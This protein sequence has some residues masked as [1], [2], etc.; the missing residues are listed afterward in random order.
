LD[1][2]VSDLSL[3]YVSNTGRDVTE[4]ATNTFAVSNPP[5]ASD[6]PATITVKVPLGMQVPPVAIRGTGTD[7]IEVEMRGLDDAVSGKH[8]L[9][10]SSFV[11]NDTLSLCHLQLHGRTVE[12][13]KTHIAAYT[14]VAELTDVVFGSIMN[15]AQLTL[16]EE[17]FSSQTWDMRTFQ[18]DTHALEFDA[19][20]AMNITNR[21]TYHTLSFGFLDVSSMTGGGGGDV[22][23]TSPRTTVM[24]TF[25]SREYYCLGGR[26]VI[27]FNT[28]CSMNVSAPVNGTAYS[29]QTHSCPQIHSAWAIPRVDTSPDDQVAYLHLAV[30]DGGIY[31]TVED[32]TA[33]G[34]QCHRGQG[35]IA[36][37]SAME[38]FGGFP[39]GF[40]T[41]G[42]SL[43][44]K[45]NEWINDGTGYDAAVVVRLYGPKELQG[46]GHWVFCTLK[47]Y[48]V[49]TIRWIT[50]VSGSI[51]TPKLA[52]L[53]A[54][55]VPNVC[56]YCPAAQAYSNIQVQG[57]I[58]ELFLQQLG[59]VTSGNDNVMLLVKQ[60]QDTMHYF[61][62]E[63]PS[64]RAEIYSYGL[65]SNLNWIRTSETLSSYPLI[66]LVLST[67]I[68]IGA[69]GV[70]CYVVWAMAIWAFN[71]HH[72]YLMRQLRYAHMKQQLEAEDEG[73]A[74]KKKV[75]S[76]NTH[77]TVVSQGILSTKV[78]K[79]L[80]ENKPSGVSRPFSHSAFFHI[81]M[82]VEFMRRS[83]VDPLELFIYS[84]PEKDG[85]QDGLVTG[86]DDAQ[87]L[88][89]EQEADDGGEVSH[90]QAAGERELNF[91]PL[92][93]FKM[94][95]N[96]FCMQH[97][98]LP[99]GK[100]QD[101]KLI[102]KLAGLAIKRNVSQVDSFVCLGWRH[103]PAATMDAIVADAANKTNRLTDSVTMFLQ[104]NC[105]AT[106]Q[107]TD[108]IPVQELSAR[109]N[110][111]CHRL[112][113]PQ[114][115]RMYIDNG[116]QQV[117]AFG[118]QLVPRQESLLVEG[119]YVDTIQV[120]REVPLAK[121]LTAELK[122]AVKVDFS[123]GNI[124]KQLKN[125]VFKRA[126]SAMDRLMA[127]CFMEIE[128]GLYRPRLQL[129]QW[130]HLGLKCIFSPYSKLWDLVLPA[131]QVGVVFLLPLPLFM[132]G[133]YVQ[134]SD[135][136]MYASDPEIDIFVWSD[137]TYLWTYSDRTVMRAKFAHMRPL[138][139]CIFF[140]IPIYITIGLA[141][142]ACHI[143]G[144]RAWDPEAFVQHSYL[145]RL[146]TGTFNSLCLLTLFAYASFVG[147][148]AAWLLLGAILNPDAFLPYGVAVLT[149]GTVALQR[150]RSLKQMYESTLEKITGCTADILNEFLL[151]P[152]KDVLAPLEA[153]EELQQAAVSKLSHLPGLD[154]IDADLLLKSIANN[155]FSG[156]SAQLAAQPLVSSLGL[157][158]DAIQCI[159]KGELDAVE[160]H[161]SK[162]LHVRSKRGRAV[163]RAILSTCPPWG[164]ASPPPGLLQAVEMLSQEANIPVP[165]AKALASF[166]FASVRYK[167]GKTQW[168]AAT[169]HLLEQ[170][171]AMEVAQKSQS[172]HP[173]YRLLREVIGSEIL[174]CVINLAL[175][176]MRGLVL[177]LERY[178]HTPA[179]EALLKIARWYS[180]GSG[181][182]T[183]SGLEPQALQSLRDDLATFS[184]KWLNIK[185][186][187]FT[188]LADLASGT[189]VQLEFLS[190]ALNLKVS[191]LRSYLQ[192]TA[193]R[194]DATLLHSAVGQLVKLMGPEPQTSSFMFGLSSTVYGNNLAD[195]QEAALRRMYKPGAAAIWCAC[196]H[197]SS[198]AAPL[199][200][201]DMR[202]VVLALKSSKQRVLMEIAAVAISGTSATAN[203]L[204]NISLLLG[205]PRHAIRHFGLCVL[206]FADNERLYIEDEEKVK[207]WKSVASRLARRARI[208]RMWRTMMM[209]PGG[210]QERANRLAKMSKEETARSLQSVG[211]KVGSIGS[212]LTVTAGRNQK[213]A[214]GSGDKSISGRALQMALSPEAPPTH[215][216][217][218]KAILKSFPNHQHQQAVLALAH[219]A[220][221][222]PTEVALSTLARLLQLDKEV[223]SLLVDLT[224][225]DF[226][227]VL[228][229]RTQEL[230]EKREKVQAAAEEAKVKALKS[231][232]ASLKAGST[233]KKIRSTQGSARSVYKLLNAHG[234]PARLG[235]GSAE[236]ISVSELDSDMVQNRFSQLPAVQ[237]LPLCRGERLKLLSLVTGLP[238]LEV[239]TTAQ[240][241]RRWCEWGEARNDFINHMAGAMN[242]NPRSMFTLMRACGIQRPSAR[243][244]RAKGSQ[245]LGAGAVGRARRMLS[246]LHD[247]LADAH[248]T[249]QDSFL[250]V[251]GEV[252]HKASSEKQ[253]TPP[254]LLEEDEEGAVP[255][256]SS[257]S[258]DIAQAVTEVYAGE[259]KVFPELTQSVSPD[260]K[261][262][263]PGVLAAVTQHAEHSTHS[264]P[265]QHAEHAAGSADGSRGAVPMN[266][267]AVTH[268]RAAAAMLMNLHSTNLEAVLC[269]KLLHMVGSKQ[270]HEKSFASHLNK[271][272]QDVGKL[273]EQLQ[274]N[275]RPPN[276]ISEQ[277]QGRILQGTGDKLASDS[278]TDTDRPA[279]DELED[280]LL[281]H[282]LTKS[283]WTSTANV[284]RGHHSFAFLG[285]Y[286]QACRMQHLAQQAA[287]RSPCAGRTLPIE[288]SGFTLPPRMWETVKQVTYTLDMVKVLH[289]E[290][291]DGHKTAAQTA[292][293]LLQAAFVSKLGD[294]KCLQEVF[295]PLV[296]LVNLRG[297]A[298]VRTNFLLALAVG[299]PPGETQIMQKAFSSG[300]IRAVT[301]VPA[302]LLSSTVAL[303]HHDTASITFAAQFF[304][305]ELR[306]SNETLTGMLAAVKHMPDTLGVLPSL[307]GIPPNLASALVAVT[308]H[309]SQPRNPRQ[310]G[311][312]GV[313]IGMEQ[314]L[315]IDNLVDILHGKPQCVTQL[316]WEKEVEEVH[317]ELLLADAIAAAAAGRQMQDH[318]LVAII[319]RLVRHVHAPLPANQMREQSSFEPGIWGSP[320]SHHGHNTPSPASPDA[321]PDTDEHN[322]GQAAMR[323]QHGISMM[324]RL[325]RGDTNA[326]A[327]LVLEL[328]EL[329]SRHWDAL[330]ALVEDCSVSPDDPDAQPRLASAAPQPDMLASTVSRFRTGSGSQGPLHSAEFPRYNSVTNNR[331]RPASI[332]IQDH[333]PYHE[334]T[335]PMQGSRRVYNKQPPREEL[336][337]LQEMSSRVLLVVEYVLRNPHEFHE[338][339][340]IW[341]DPS[342][343]VPM[344]NNCQAFFMDV[345]AC[346]GRVEC[347]QL[348]QEAAWVLPGVTMFSRMMMLSAAIVLPD[349]YML[350]VPAMEGQL[351][352]SDEP[353]PAQCSP[354]NDAVNT[355]AEAEVPL[356]PSPESA[357]K[358]SAAAQPVAM[359]LKSCESLV[360]GTMALVC[361]DWKVLTKFGDALLHEL[362]LVRDES[363]DVSMS[364]TDQV[365]QEQEAAQ[366][367]SSAVKALEMLWLLVRGDCSKA[368]DALAGGVEPRT[369][370]RAMLQ[371]AQPNERYCANLVMLHRLATLDRNDL[372][373]T[374]RR[375][376][377]NGIT[378]LH[379]LRRSLF[380]GH[381]MRSRNE[382]KK[383]C[384]TL[385]KLLM[386]AAGG[387]GAMGISDLEEV[388]EHL[389]VAAGGASRNF[390][391]CVRLAGRE[392][393]VSPA[394]LEGLAGIGLEPESIL[395]FTR[396]MQGHR[397]SL[398]ELASQLTKLTGE[399]G[400]E[401]I[402][403]RAL[404]DVKDT[405]QDT[406]ELLGVFGTV[407][408]YIINLVLRVLRSIGAVA[409][410]G[411]EQIKKVAPRVHQSAGGEAEELTSDEDRFLDGM[412]ALFA[413]A[414]G[415]VKGA[416][417]MLQSLSREER[418]SAIETEVWNILEGY[419][420]LVVGYGPGAL[421]C[422]PREM[423]QRHST[424]LRTAL[425]LKCQDYASLKH[426]LP[427]I[428]KA[429]DPTLGVEDPANLMQTDRLLRT[430]CGHTQAS[431]ELA[432]LANGRQ[433]MDLAF[434]ISALIDPSVTKAS[435]G[436]ELGKRNTNWV[437]YKHGLE[438]AMVWFQVP[439]SVQQSLHD[440]KK[441]L[442]YTLMRKISRNCTGVELACIQQRLL[443]SVFRLEQRPAVQELA[444]LTYFGNC[445]MNSVLEQLMQ[446]RP[447][448][449]KEPTFDAE[450][451]PESSRQGELATAENVRGTATLLVEREMGA[452]QA[453][454]PDHPESSGS[455]ELEI[456]PREEAAKAKA[457]ES[458]AK[459]GRIITTMFTSFENPEHSSLK[460]LM[461]LA[462]RLLVKPEQGA[463]YAKALSKEMQLFFEALLSGQT[464]LLKDTALEQVL[465]WLVNNE[466][467][468]HD[469]V[470]VW[471]GFILRMKLEDDHNP[472][473]ELEEL[474]QMAK[475]IIEMAQLNL[476]EAD[477]LGFLQILV[478]VG[479][480]DVQGS[481]KAM[482]S[483]NHVM[484]N[485]VQLLIQL[486]EGLG[487]LR[488]SQ[489]S[490]K[491]GKDGLLVSLKLNLT[492]ERRMELLSLADGGTGVIKLEGMAEAVGTVAKELAEDCMRILNISWDFLIVLFVSAISYL[493]L[494]MIFLFLGIKAFSSTSTFGSIVESLCAAGAG[495]GSSVKGAIQDAKA[496]TFDI[497]G[498]VKKAWSRLTLDDNESTDGAE[499]V[500]SQ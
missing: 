191:E 138:L 336:S 461:S 326:A 227:R 171:L 188:A 15:A 51:L 23:I 368:A 293:L 152:L 165:I 434:F 462:L 453:E 134:S 427:E 255:E 387:R 201:H 339:N 375:K 181:N 249:T 193:I 369:S 69:G 324:I 67:V 220:S 232:N 486:L 135:R 393:E 81:E 233:L 448:T 141:A 128:S 133:L 24:K 127:Q 186:D 397:T 221:G 343:S 334:P 463:E 420:S 471:I 348:R 189:K 497:K 20:D 299:A 455:L 149:T 125:Q 298:E 272:L 167:N 124:Q 253:R 254:T 145:K 392:P 424:L 474:G 156:I 109:Y 306:V 412:E 243:L 277:I 452:S 438:Q 373:D 120:T 268:A 447:A 53:R 172:G 489:G 87:T 465:P 295:L 116:T 246:A 169:E 33:G 130:A 238:T 215:D 390:A 435:S 346:F 456:E 139:K 258:G 256:A 47:A 113:I 70:S 333:E 370:L 468:L 398:T 314:M 321:Q 114:D 496:D 294:H 389:G 144:L 217:L 481:L 205:V 240:Q 307:M 110:A 276:I 372:P 460:D 80:V 107:E 49:L 445:H 45:H 21:S 382:T 71:K 176:D 433:E 11:F 44:S 248:P 315:A 322:R 265:A 415:D 146:I 153:L 431:L 219:M 351:D 354:D 155:D 288:D 230:I 154:S 123:M 55:L 377:M 25:S 366:S 304:Q 450:I 443:N 423:P 185:A 301:R 103:L 380:R 362:R 319:Q 13:G 48:I 166:M 68:G 408:G 296:R 63:G 273:G 202:S 244:G 121:M 235:T 209:L 96:R 441:V 197:S 261:K 148:L 309:S 478:A 199:N 118:A 340:A 218:Q 79:V 93:R 271:G 269:H 358:M 198:E 316:D 74:K 242:I 275:F 409:I 60:V 410:E 95:F 328:T 62:N 413:A 1:P 10:M 212:K 89:E 28:S 32:L 84:L 88:A 337:E 282:M 395:H 194:T 488:M 206:L 182:D 267:A 112:R 211:L 439:L 31:V 469:K 126:Q 312:L 466:K 483:L 106:G 411:K 364:N 136:V 41:L 402:F 270:I 349:T 400:A 327:E 35:E 446:R 426:T 143:T 61:W 102:L 117:L 104:T 404:Q 278:K 356:E 280:E 317:H 132:I 147:M 311:A 236:G 57:T 432:S 310:M 345:A 422:L 492:D 355:G 451:G 376:V 111:F 22:F 8:Y 330:G 34:A 98:I 391:A 318:Q 442:M 224:M 204:P 73:R 500:Q 418:W 164:R 341:K 58:S 297:E 39:G 287:S 480:Q 302:T 157:S 213:A 436:S 262:L 464:Q 332:G 177:L 401:N 352:V 454:F 174:T 19:L 65:G 429:L 216:E 56:P 365:R 260:T 234:A 283:L 263:R 163:I 17:S 207:S 417:G 490:G 419:K 385:Q 344:F 367:L 325:G 458:L 305:G 2:A 281:D 192:A 251:V 170:I 416:L 83:F 477:M 225:G 91:V 160:E 72:A 250:G 405:V 36:Q 122:E 308:N 228:G 374:L 476:T 168:N 16:L 284:V 388:A 77:V 184:E 335:T 40:D 381:E 85:S 428:A 9:Q 237:I 162:A 303:F 92:K 179:S 99:Y 493:T 222:R 4:T 484:P 342:A 491:A 158:T 403:D 29:N 173:P 396:A 394:E 119:L 203:M 115:Q 245:K 331:D 137:W 108:A 129:H 274:D 444:N 52:T 472:E 241:V 223:I 82:L 78:A 161:V 266:L 140:V 100:I 38:A 105:V 252:Q 43:L 467:E 406:L 97:G 231:K 279:S 175:G 264:E 363:K 7:E 378:D 159:L 487:A 3:S 6:L 196:L 371:H 421:S 26:E 285:L 347:S 12:I 5:A 151:Q 208:R 498:T 229:F 259:V 94:E 470:K 86:M 457:A 459:K 359:T 383:I 384:Q 425:L 183:G 414:Q 289:M 226:L 430:A 190:E 195:E 200:V 292:M 187:A 239:I 257:R 291:L 131:F 399:E 499:L 290:E 379:S 54:R 353:F 214:P 150:Y 357:A 479:R 300:H 247:I 64:E 180:Y 338:P 90:E 449:A 66:V 101:K 437:K 495:V 440:S 75:A 50:A 46:I 286:L 407:I 14:G 76:R 329:D 386:L 210:H 473:N 42:G 27:N 494:I 360:V 59:F 142:F 350:L 30:M 361:G 485:Q 482:N 323:L 320:P 178:W 475:T 313:L 37:S 18:K